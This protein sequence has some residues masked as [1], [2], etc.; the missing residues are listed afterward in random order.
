MNQIAYELNR[1]K[2]GR[3]TPGDKQSYQQGDNQ[4]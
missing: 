1:S 3:Q 2:D 4:P